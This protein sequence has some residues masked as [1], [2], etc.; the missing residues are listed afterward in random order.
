MTR[1]AIA[2][3]GN[4]GDVAAAFAQALASL[5]AHPDI[6]ILARSSVYRTPP[7]GVVDQPDFLNMAALIETGLDPRALLALC[8]SIE[9]DGGRV[10]SLRW[11]PRRIDIDLIA[12]GDVV[13][14]TDDLTLPH[15]R[16][17]ERAFVLA[18]LAEIAPEMKLGGKTVQEWLART[19]AA[20][21]RVDPQ[22]GATLAAA[23]L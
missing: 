16:A 11:G 18:P 20:G 12:Y 4:V 13:M 1:A 19:D 3:G 8:L 5:A 6:R 9:R 23:G 14:Q 21:V 17:H 22:A 10:R 15:P 7:W 2:L